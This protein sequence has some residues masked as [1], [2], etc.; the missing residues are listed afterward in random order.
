MKQVL[1]YGD[2]NTWGL[3]PGTT[4]RY[5]WGVRWTSILQEKL[6]NEEVRIIEEGLCGRIIRTGNGFVDTRGK[7]TL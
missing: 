7:L 2:S 6:K 1:V 4:E 3:I 5:P